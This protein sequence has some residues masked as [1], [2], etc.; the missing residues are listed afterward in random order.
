MVFYTMSA[1][2]TTQM[3]SDPT[4]EKPEPNASR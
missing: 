3:S 2:L 1:G 4:W